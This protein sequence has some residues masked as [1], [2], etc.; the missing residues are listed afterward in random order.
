[1]RVWKAGL[2]AAAVLIGGATPAL[3][4]TPLDFI[5]EATA[6]LQIVMAVLIAA[7]IA[8]VIVFGRKLA[9][10]PHV[11]GGSAFISGLRL[12]G[13]TL[14]CLGA[15]YGVFNSMIGIVTTQTDSLSVIAPGLA[16]A[17][18]VFMMGLI[19][20]AVASLAHWVIEARLDRSVLR[21]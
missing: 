3:A 5:L 14:G 11:S 13:P 21:S 18:L 10:G 15:A 8:T 7:T 17:T 2:L 19:S 9:S 4:L 1:M 20:G 6:P 12:G 16:E